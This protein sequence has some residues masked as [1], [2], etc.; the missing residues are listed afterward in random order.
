MMNKR[1]RKKVD[2]QLKV[3]IQALNN[4]VARSEGFSLITEKEIEQTL[5]RVKQSKSSINRTL[6]DYKNYIVNA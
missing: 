4:D 3:A 1:Q 2:Q 5:E 6:R